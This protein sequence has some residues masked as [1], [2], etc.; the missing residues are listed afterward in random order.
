[1]SDY[2]VADNV[3]ED[4]LLKVMSDCLLTGSKHTKTVLLSPF[5]QN[6][7]TFFFVLYTVKIAL[8]TWPVIV[9]LQV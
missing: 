9:F 2:L 7:L 3:M 6:V 4:I 8:L 1:M 5:S